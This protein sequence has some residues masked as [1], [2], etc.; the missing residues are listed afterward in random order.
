VALILLLIALA[1]VS[2]L[3]LV[4]ASRRERE[5]AIRRALGVSRA[6]LFEQLLTESVLLAVV[7]GAVALLMAVWV[8]AA[9]RGLLLPDVRWATGVLDLRVM[10]F[11]GGAAI[12]TGIVVGLVPAI[13]ARGGRI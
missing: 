11:A 6:R 13:H 5:I 7:G 2:N 10:A 9:L 8:G 1:N 4:R 12:L 3:L